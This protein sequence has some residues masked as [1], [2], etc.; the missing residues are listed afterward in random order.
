MSSF[1]NFNTTYLHIFLETHTRAFLLSTLPSVTD[2]VVH[3]MG[4]MPPQLEQCVRHA[5]ILLL[6]PFYFNNM[7]MSFGGL[8]LLTKLTDVIYIFIEF[9]SSSQFQFVRR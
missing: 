7:Y 4:L 5:L 8:G 6:C 9:I 3:T 2:S 1:V